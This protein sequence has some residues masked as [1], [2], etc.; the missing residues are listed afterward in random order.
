[1]PRV[2]KNIDY[3]SLTVWL[4]PEDKAKLDALYN[5]F[6]IFKGNKQE[7]HRTLIRL[8]YMSSAGKITLADKSVQTQA[9]FTASR[10]DLDKRIQCQQ[11]GLEVKANLCE[12]CRKRRLYPTCPKL[13][14]VR[15]G[16]LG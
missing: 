12:E 14:V 15:L 2:R 11:T 4:H 13:E 1:M 8:V 7:K 16:F 9:N 3:Y 5:R 10:G 6:S